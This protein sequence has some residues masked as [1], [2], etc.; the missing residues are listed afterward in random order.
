MDIETS[1]AA[2]DVVEGVDFL[3][4]RE[5]WDQ[6]SYAV[7]SFLVRY[8]DLTLRAYRQDMLSF[9]RWCAERQL[10]PLEAERP[11]LELYLR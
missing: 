11:H 9:L 8:R 2:D 1:S 3:P 7:A 10:P 5:R 4:A 6:T